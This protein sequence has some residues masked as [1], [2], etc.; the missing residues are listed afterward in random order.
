MD[1]LEE[2]FQRT[3]RSFENTEKNSLYGKVETVKDLVLFINEQ[4]QLKNT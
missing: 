3:N 4:P 1:I 2:I